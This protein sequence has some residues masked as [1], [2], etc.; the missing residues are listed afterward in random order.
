MLYPGCLGEKTVKG[1][2]KMRGSKC[3]LA[4]GSFLCRPQTNAQRLGSV[5]REGKRRQ[6]LSLY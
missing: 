3:K 4:Q 6:L 2:C 1:E 5:C